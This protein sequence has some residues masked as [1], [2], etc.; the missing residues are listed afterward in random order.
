VIAAGSSGPC[1]N[2]LS[3]KLSSTNM[4]DAKTSLKYGA[5]GL[6]KA[7][8]RC[9]AQYP[10]VTRKPQTAPIVYDK[11]IRPRSRSTGHSASKDTPSP[12][13]Y[14]KFVNLRPHAVPIQS[15]A[16]RKSRALGLPAI[17]DGGGVIEMSPPSTNTLLR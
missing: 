11:N 10:P 13:A 5:I 4:G 12:I 14:I 8:Q 3:A 16:K 2:L 6:P 7:S 9:T 1:M 17:S 15:P